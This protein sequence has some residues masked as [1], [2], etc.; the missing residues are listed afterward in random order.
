MLFG[1]NNF[2]FCAFCDNTFYVLASKTIGKNKILGGLA[3]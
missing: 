3:F 1:F 2:E